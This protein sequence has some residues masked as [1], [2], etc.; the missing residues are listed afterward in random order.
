MPRAIAVLSSFGSGHKPRRQHTRV[1]A[2]NVGLEEAAESDR[3][4]SL[5]RCRRPYVFVAMNIAKERAKRS[6]RLIT[7]GL[8]G[9]TMQRV[10]VAL[11]SGPTTEQRVQG[12]GSAER[13]AARLEPTGEHA[14][15]QHLIWVMPAKGCARRKASR[16]HRILKTVGGGFL[17]GRATGPERLRKESGHGRDCE[18]ARSRRRRD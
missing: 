6:G 15:P 16:P 11:Q 12:C 1:P 7:L 4:A 9:V 3:F 14:N 5:A 18:S 8:S 2:G 13:R 17:C 10:R